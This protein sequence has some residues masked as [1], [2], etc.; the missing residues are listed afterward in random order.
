MAQSDLYFYSDTSLNTDDVDHMAAYEGVGDLGSDSSLCCRNWNK[1]EYILA[2][3][4]LVNGGDKD[5]T[6][7]VVMVESVSPA[8]EPATMLLFGTGIAG[9]FG[10]TKRRKMKK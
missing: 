1:G 3:E 8:P 7:F 5:Y 9:L 2:W 10:V 4:D 6:D